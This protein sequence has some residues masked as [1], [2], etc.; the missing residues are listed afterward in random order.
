MKRLEENSGIMISTGELSDSLFN[1]VLRS[2]VA[3]EEGKQSTKRKR[4][5]AEVSGQDIVIPKS[6]GGYS[7]FLRI[8]STRVVSSANTERKKKKK[9]QH[10]ELT[11]MV[12]DSPTAEHPRWFSSCEMHVLG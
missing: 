1:D 4:N 8:L 9:K 7:V 6:V 2:F 5:H 3:A 11:D 12:E 10:L